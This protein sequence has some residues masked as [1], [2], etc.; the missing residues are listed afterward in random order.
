VDRQN[1]M[2]W[3]EEAKPTTNQA[4]SADVEVFW[5]KARQNPGEVRGA[6][7]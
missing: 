6:I 7:G 5:E 4:R 3:Q 2:W 1:C